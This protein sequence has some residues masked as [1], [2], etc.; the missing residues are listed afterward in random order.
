M[1]NTDSP[2]KDLLI[3]RVKSKALNNGTPSQDS[4]S[5]EIENRLF[6]N[7]MRIKAQVKYQQ[8]IF[9]SK[10]LQMKS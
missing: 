3:T 5:K 2:S 4:N 7:M 8:D 6:K 10:L 9:Q 1:I